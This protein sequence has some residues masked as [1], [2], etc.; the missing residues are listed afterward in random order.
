M[1]FHADPFRRISPIAFGM[2]REKSD[3]LFDFIPVSLDELDKLTGRESNDTEEVQVR[4]WT[5]KDLAQ[6]FT[7]EDGSNHETSAEFPSKGTS[8]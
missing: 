6:N 7:L 5:N 2:N 8:G 3:S 1:V 4:L